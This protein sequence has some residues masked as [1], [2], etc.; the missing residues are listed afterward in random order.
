MRGSG[1][2]AMTPAKPAGLQVD[3]WVLWVPYV[4][5]PALQDQAS[6]IKINY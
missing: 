4:P 1:L 6:V 3:D 5:V 2:C